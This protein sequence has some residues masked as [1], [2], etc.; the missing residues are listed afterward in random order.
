MIG[1][2]FCFCS[3]NHAWTYNVVFVWFSS[4]R[5]WWCFLAPVMQKWKIS[6]PLTLI[7]LFVWTRKYCLT[8]FHQLHAISCFVQRKVFQTKQ[9][10]YWRFPALPAPTS[11]GRMKG[12]IPKNCSY[13][14]LLIPDINIKPLLRFEISEG[15]VFFLAQVK[16][17]C[18]P[19]GRYHIEAAAGKSKREVL[20]ALKF[21]SFP[22]HSTKLAPTQLSAYICQFLI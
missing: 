13:L 21:F 12:Y 15:D 6:H 4:V 11:N 17:M 8:G 7:S 10:T 16:N 22:S 3:L 2:Y 19:P 20:K 14:G 18:R 5:Q 1:V 9:E